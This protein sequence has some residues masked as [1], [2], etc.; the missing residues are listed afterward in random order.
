MPDHD[1][2]YYREQFKRETGREFVRSPLEPAQPVSVAASLLA[3][4]K[5]LWPLALLIA[6]VLFLK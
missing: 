4:V 2:D 6:G 5:Y 3:I 1:V